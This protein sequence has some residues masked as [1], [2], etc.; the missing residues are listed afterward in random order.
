MPNGMP[1][2][3][4]GEITDSGD[5]YSM[6]VGTVR[7][8]PICPDGVALPKLPDDNFDDNFVTACAIRLTKGYTENN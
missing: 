8:Y 7:I 6:D 2:L 4:Q 5:T 3:I 1:F